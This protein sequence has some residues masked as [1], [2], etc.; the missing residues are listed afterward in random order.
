[1]LLKELLPIVAGRTSTLAG[2]PSLIMVGI[3]IN[4]LLATETIICPPGRLLRVLALV[5]ATAAI[6]AFAWISK[7]QPGGPAKGSS[8][9]DMRHGHLA[10]RRATMVGSKAS[11][12]APQT[13]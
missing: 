11:V 7:R 3:G 6:A 10:Q 13:P 5:T 9:S 12:A 2:E 4:R 8:G 1:M